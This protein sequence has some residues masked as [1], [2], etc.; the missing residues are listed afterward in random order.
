MSSSIGSKLARLHSSFVQPLI[1]WLT[2]CCWY[3]N[4]FASYLFALD[5][6]DFSYS[7]LIQVIKSKTA[8]GFIGNFAAAG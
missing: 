7:N 4:I 6:R 1:F 5:A 8:Q 2:I 3:S